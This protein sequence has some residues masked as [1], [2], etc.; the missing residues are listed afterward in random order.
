M[1]VAGYRFGPFALASA[2][3]PLLR[4][5][6]AVKL[7]PK[8]LLLLWTL[9]REAG[10]VVGKPALFDAVWPRHVVAES[11]L[12]FQ[13]Q[14]L[15]TALGDDPRAPRYIAT[16]H[17]IGFRFVA[18]VSSA[19]VGHAPGAGCAP[20]GRDEPFQRLH[21]AF[22]RAFGGQRQFVFVTGEAGIGKTALLERFIEEL[23]AAPERPLL[24]RGRSAEHY[25]E[26]EPY[27]PVIEALHYLCRH[28]GDGTALELLRRDAPAW[29]SQLSGL[30][31]VEER[32]ALEGRAPGASP[33]R[34]RRE[35]NDVLE[36]LCATR[37][38]VLVLE[39]LHW[40][41]HASIDL[42]AAIAQRSEPARLLVLATYRPVEAT[43]SR[44]PVHRLKLDLDM[45]AQARELRLEPLRLADTAAYLTQ[46]YPQYGDPTGLAALVHRHGGGLPLFMVHL[47]EA[48][49]T[50][51]ADGELALPEELCDL[52]G[53][54][55]ERLDPAQ[56]QVLEAGS[57]EG[58]E[59]TAAGVAA[60]LGLDLAEVETLCDRLVRHGQFIADRALSVWPDGTASGRY[61]FRH[62]L[63]QT[64]LYRR[65]G[66]SARRRMHQRYAER[67][68]A[69]YAGREKDCAVEL[70]AHFASAHDV[71]R[72]ARYHEAAA[73]VAVR[74][75]APLQAAAHLRRALA[76][77]AV[78]PLSR[79]RER[80]ELG[81]QLKLGEALT[82]GMG[83]AAL[84]ASLAFRRAAELAQA[85]TEDAR[86][87]S[88]LWGLFL[89]HLIRA[90][91]DRAQTLGTRL[92]DLA[93]THPLDA[94]MNLRARL[95]LGAVLLYRGQFEAAWTH[96]EPGLKLCDL[97]LRHFP[98]T[99]SHDLRVECMATASWL[100]WLRGDPDQARE[101]SRQAVA[102]ASEGTTARSL[103]VALF[104]QSVLYR[105]LDD[106]QACAVAE[107]LRRCAH[108]NALV[109]WERAADI[110]LGADAA[111]RGELP[112]E[113][114]QELVDARRQMGVGLGVV[115]DLL[116]VGRAHARR[117]QIES[118]RR[119]L[120]Q[121]R[122]LMRTNGERLWEAELHLI[123]AEL[124]HAPVPM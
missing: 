36:R 105:L 104:R 111:E 9:L 8:T 3:G 79:E 4:D 94:E 51:H 119:V 91:F 103:E 62:A 53:L 118:G 38:L 17:R 73:D 88:A 5:G 7:Q 107:T 120:A 83:Y 26:E 24:A 86:H 102:L 89:F 45:R 112:V 37:P 71:V 96:F 41:D 40:S 42:L 30:L 54:Q 48:L 27:G 66:T 14:L 115:L 60:M 10:R 58:V 46:R 65:G 76:A 1:Q 77:L 11:A 114:L 29:L 78:W 95:A 100:L 31:G 15:R 110:L 57:V 56:R 80:Q 39:D 92:L 18:A 121:A 70:A 28:D 16:V 72:S 12:S 33:G 117:N 55:L 52:I 47:A 61:G 82:D 101:R 116:L 35:L 109:H 64:V 49:A 6:V 43:M 32:R 85:L 50:R 20:I 122:Q 25:G 19:A 75:C 99:R 124:R 69:A 98:S 97:D 13:I 68:E 74:R 59:F 23:Q 93:Q 87:A 22:A 84:E 113:S 44:H 108:D 90:E 21:E 63:Y 2:Q 67:L 34:Q 106:A 123:E 81:L